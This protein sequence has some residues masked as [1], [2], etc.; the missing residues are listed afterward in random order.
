MREFHVF[1]VDKSTRTFADNL[2]VFGWARVLDELLDR[3]VGHGNDVTIIDRGAYYELTCLPALIISDDWTLDRQLS[4]IFPIQTTKNADT[5]PPDIP[6]VLDYETDRDKVNQY[7][8]ERKKGVENPTSPPLYW[9]MERAINPLTLPGYNSLVIDWWNLGE[10][11]SDALRLLFELF[12]RTPNDYEQAIAAWNELNKVHEWGIKAEATCQQLFNPDQGKGQNKTKADGLSIGN[13]NAFWLA[14]WLKAIGFFEAALTRTVRGAKD[15]KTFVVAPRK[16]SFS[17]S[18]AVM[19]EFRKTMITETSTKFDIFAALRYARALL[20]HFS[21]EETLLAQLVGGGS[22]QQKVV[23]GFDT[24]FY[25]DLGNATATMNVSF[26]ALPGWIVVDSREDIALFTDFDN[27]LLIHLERLTRQ[28]DEGHSDAFTLLQ[29]L[30]D[31]VSGDN[32]EAFFRFT[33]A[34]V[35]Y[36]IGKREHNQY[37]YQLRTDF[38]ERLIM[39]TEKR[40]TPILENSGFQNI[41]YAIRQSTVTAQY[42]KTQG[43]RKYDVRYGLGQDLARKS[44]YPDEFVA[45]LSDFLHKFNAENAQVMEARPGPYRR[46]IRTSDIDEIVWLIDEYGSEVVANLLIAYGYARM[47]REE[48]EFSEVTQQ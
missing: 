23:A 24:A 41:A 12:A 16:L 30:R 48:D 28:F 2:L 13:V 40:L 42:R 47:P 32:L 5:M 10:F 4:P 9:E 34:F 18:N 15:R 21:E 43:D 38:I 14:E 46:S 31:F 29:H 35:S 27:G 19:G 44:R 26:I 7:F 22:L 6:G 37:A 45:A 3:Q 20:D 17:A 8:D 39:S 33:N 36:Y 1:Y 11:Q 25:M